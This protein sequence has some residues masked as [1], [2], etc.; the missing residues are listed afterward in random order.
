MASGDLDTGWHNFSWGCHH[1]WYGILH[2][3]NGRTGSGPLEQTGCKDCS[4]VKLRRGSQRLGVPYQGNG[5]WAFLGLGSLF[6][7]SYFLLGVRRRRRAG[8]P[9]DVQGAIILSAFLLGFFAVAVFQVLTHK[10]CVFRPERDR[11]S[12]HAGPDAYG[13][14][15]LL[16]IIDDQNVLSFTK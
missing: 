14:E 9:I 6:A 5:W 7:L 16:E 10:W 1:F 4:I 15:D 13:R 12:G 3:K 11:F 2:I 8:L